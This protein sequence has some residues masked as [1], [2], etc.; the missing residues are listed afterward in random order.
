MLI[1]LDLSISH[2]KYVNILS[3]IEVYIFL[4]GPAEDDILLDTLILI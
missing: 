1:N 2:L 4:F 3:D